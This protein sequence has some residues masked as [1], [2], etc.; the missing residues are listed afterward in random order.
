MFQAAS[1]TR[2]WT[3]KRRFWRGCADLTVRRCLATFFPDKLFAHDFAA[4]SPNQNIILGSRPR[5]E[6]HDKSFIQVQAEGN[7]ATGLDERRCDLRICAVK[8]E[9]DES[10]IGVPKLFTARCA[11][12][13]LPM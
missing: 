1:V 11:R 4:H 8:I 10:S 9:N 5:S 13:S 6:P 3:G 7:I 12:N 2:Q